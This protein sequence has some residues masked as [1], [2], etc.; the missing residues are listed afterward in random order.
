MRGRK[1][2]IT[3]FLYVTTKII[4]YDKSTHTGAA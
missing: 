2:S 3:I 1:E 4:Q